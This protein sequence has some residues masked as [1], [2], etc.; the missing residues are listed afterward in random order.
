MLPDMPEG[1]ANRTHVTHIRR[2]LEMGKINIIGGSHLKVEFPGTTE[3]D[4]EWPVQSAHGAAAKMRV[5]FLNPQKVVIDFKD[6]PPA[7]TP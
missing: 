5:T 4:M 1:T 3:P 7:G 2:R 6:P